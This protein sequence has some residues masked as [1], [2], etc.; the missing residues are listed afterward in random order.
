MVEYRQLKMRIF[1][2]LFYKFC[3]IVLYGFFRLF[4]R[5]SIR[6]RQNIPQDRNFILIA[7]HRSYWDVPLLA[8]AFGI[9]H[10]I[11]FVA[12]ETLIEENFIIGNL[13]KWFAIL[14]D[15]EKFR[16][17]DLKI[18]LKSL[19]EGKIL[20][21][22]PEGTTLTTDKIYRGVFLFAQR[23]KKELLP[24]NIASRGPYP[25]RSPFRLPKIIVQIGSPFWVKDL[26]NQLKEGEFD[27]EK[28]YEQMGK[29]LLE[30]IDNPTGTE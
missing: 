4:L 21:I 30:R 10:R 5:L 7:R 28:K 9:K 23:A 25:P 20:G 13:V 17:S 16:H 19:R 6:G 15:R 24:V 12:R 11:Y 29:L 18:I 22:F 26:R 1:K 2:E 3:C 27:Q 14:I 8:A